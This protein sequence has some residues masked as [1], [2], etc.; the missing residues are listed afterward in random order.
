M[1]MLMSADCQSVCRSPWTSACAWS[2]YNVHDS[3]DV[4]L[5]SLTPVVLHHFGVCHHQCFHP[6]L[7]ADWAL[8]NSSPPSPLAT[9]PALSLSLS[10]I[11][12]N[13]IWRWMKSKQEIK[14]KRC[15]FYSLYTSHSLTFLA[16]G[17][18]Q[19]IS[20]LPLFFLF[21]YL[22]IKW[23]WRTSSVSALILLLLFC[24]LSQAETWF[25]KYKKF[26]FGFQEAV[27]EP[28]RK[29]TKKCPTLTN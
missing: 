13:R 16:W 2:T 19:P 11:N 3:Q 23:T 24:F 6:L 10:V 5:H 12:T 25:L 28:W 14:K 4:A 20:P 15:D 27:D 29:S 9:F 21:S 26:Q 8:M 22:N 1:L 17:Q 18:N 7:S